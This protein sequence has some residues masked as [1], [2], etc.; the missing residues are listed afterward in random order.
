MRAIRLR[1]EYLNNPIGIDIVKPRFFWNAYEGITQSAYQIKV[2]TDKKVLWDSGKVKSHRMTGIVYQGEKLLS[3]TRATWQVCLWDENDLQGSWSEEATFEMGLLNPSDWQAK[4][5][6]GDYTVNKGKRTPVDCFHKAFTATDIVHAQ[7][8]MTACG[9]YEGH[10]NGQR[11][12]D[13]ILAPGITDYQ[14]RIQY[15]TYDVTAL[16]HKGANTL[17][18]ELADGWFRGSTGG[19]GLKNQYG[20]ETK[21]LVQL[22]LTDSRGN[23]TFVCTDESWH[24]SNDGSIRFADNQDGETVDAN[25][26]PSYS[27]KAKGTHW[28]AVPSAANNV[29]L[30][31]HETFKPILIKTP[32]GATV[33]DF[34][35]NIAGYVQFSL[36]AKK[37]QEIFLRFGEMLDTN[38]EFT[39]KNIQCSNKKITTPLQQV[40]YTCKAGMNEYKTRFAIFGFRYVLVETDV[41]LKPEDFTA[42]AVYSDMEDTLNFESSNGLLNQFVDIT[43]WSTKGNSADL[44][45]DCP[46]RERHGWAGDAQIFFNTAGYLFSYA[47][48]ARKFI[49]D[50]TDWQKKNGC[51]PQ[52]AP[53]GGMDFYMAPLNG[54]VGWSDA[55]VMMPYRMWKLYGDESIIRD[56]YD[57]MRR[58]AIFMQKRL[59]K[60]YPTRRIIKLP[61]ATKRYIA[62]YG[63]AYGEWAE[64]EDV[65][66]LVLSDM[67]IPHPEE[68]TAYTCYVMS[69]MAEIALF[70]GK[71]NDA[72]EYQH[73][74]TETR[75]AYQ[76]LSELKKFTL[77]TDRQARLVRPLYFNLLNETQTEFAKKRLIEALEH[78]GWRLGTG[79]LST[80]LILDVLSDM[81]IELAY[82]LLENEQM[83]GWLFMPKNGATTVW[84]SWEGT[85]AQGGIASLNHYSKGAVCE[86]LFRVMCGVTVKGENCFAIAPK[87]GGQFTNAGLEYQSIYGKVASK[88]EKMNGK[89]TYHFAI[90]ANCTAEITLPCGIQKNVTAGTYTF[91]EGQDGD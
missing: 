2:L 72:Q 77:D 50:M 42:I 24:W 82:R 4:W 58:Y 83:P 34:G 89:T 39:Q 73:Y 78:Y 1:L 47:P 63:Q 35:Q 20:T 36:N 55:G 61:K 53:Q 29:P 88:W 5:I 75:K 74:E 59:G 16:L 13:Y 71:Q 46:T 62:N 17:T 56:N 33:L 81:D 65:N 30:T 21:L 57:A 3:R 52:I 9:V 45:T 70:L 32:S 10:L 37:G 84:E 66:K 31:E 6:T 38:G 85:E 19:W 76:E 79:F 7:I 11:I 67:A 86:W 22:E 60:W 41:K 51:F 87:P 40:R 91:T 48:F 64:P 27:G 49:R 44:P 26:Q 54:S 8:Y 14:K 68:A 28:H 18:F 90:P 80:P 25:K 43:R 12:G 15:Q 23:V 69:L